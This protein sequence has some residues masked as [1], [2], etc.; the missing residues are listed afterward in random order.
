MRTTCAQNLSIIGGYLLEYC[1]QNPPKLGLIGSQA[2]KM[3]GIF[4][5]KSR[6]ANTQKVKLVDPQTMEKCRCYIGY[7]RIWAGPR[8]QFR[9]NFSNCSKMHQ[10]I[11][12]PS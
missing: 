8:E 7:V 12:E 11:S 2:P 1:P 4:Q 9:P 5:V 3:R 6:M 10:Q